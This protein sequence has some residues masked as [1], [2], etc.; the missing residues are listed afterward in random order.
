M[1]F[2]IEME[3]LLKPK[4][5]LNPFLAKHK[6]NHAVKPKRAREEKVDDKKA[7]DKKA[8]DDKA[9]AQMAREISDIDNN[10][11]AMRE[12]IAE[13]LTQA[14]VVA[15]LQSK[16]YEDWTIKAEPSLDE[17]PDDRGGGYCKSST[18]T[19]PTVCTQKLITCR[20]HRNRFADPVYRGDKVV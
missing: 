11:K 6:F 19:G 18:G 14:S 15:K 2:G 1:S 5:G 7:K 12:A 10:R 8:K 20:G 13:V 16:K 4:S 17:V 9:K 3:L